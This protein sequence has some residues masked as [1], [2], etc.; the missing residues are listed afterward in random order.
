MDK[1]KF[2]QEAY[3]D[4]KIT[5]EIRR[6]AFAYLAKFPGASVSLAISFARLQVNVV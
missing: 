3:K 4:G 1:Q 6:A 2:I 5:N